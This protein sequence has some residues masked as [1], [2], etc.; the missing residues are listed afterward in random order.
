MSVSASSAP[1]ALTAGRILID[2]RLA[3]GKAVLIADGR[4]AG[5]AGLAEVPAGLPLADLGADAILAPGFIDWQVNGGGGVMLNDQPT[6]AGMKTI[7]AA[8]RRFGTTRLL[9][10]LIT[11]TPDVMARLAE[12]AATPV[13]GVLGWHLEGPFLSPERKGIHRADFIRPLDAADVDVLKAFAGGRSVV[14]LAPERAAPG[15][16][17]RLVEAGLIVSLG[18]SATDAAHALRAVDEGATAVT[19]LFNAMSQMVGRE[20]GLVGTAFDDDRLV[21][22]MIPDGIH[23]AAANMRTAFK[24]MGSERL[25]LVTDAMSTIGLDDGVDP[26]F[27]L[28]GREIRLSRDS[29]NGD[30]L[31]GADGTLA[32]AHL[33]MIEAV[34]R[35]VKLVG[36]PLETALAMASATPAKLLG[37]AD[38]FGQ[39]A[40]GYVADLVA[41]DGQYRVLNT[42]VDGV[43][44]V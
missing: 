22:G 42:W 11:D 15:T 38:R 39:I 6:A 29:V 3:A 20:P 26:T 35:T 5:V 28:M 34:A 2:G 43:P 7:V 25:S 9:P 24:A 31:T 41:F 19:H 16:V 12:A 18:H 23:I 33:A 21:A 10:T 1:A 32:G 4:I 30:R 37:V 13:Q 14:T 8:H 36:V 17:A 27:Q 44:N 40:S